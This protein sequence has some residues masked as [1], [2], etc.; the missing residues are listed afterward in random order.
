MSQPPHDE[1]ESENGKPPR[2]EPSPQPVAEGSFGKGMGVAALVVGLQA[3]FSLLFFF[4]SS[5]EGL[6]FTVIS[7]F[8]TLG[9][10]LYY[11]IRKRSRL[12][13]IGFLIVLACTWLVFLGPCTLFGIGL[14]ETYS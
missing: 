1:H 14:T 9:I 4:G 13:G 11:A 2:R 10:G 8:V 12:T 6:Q 5:L 3:L 7:F